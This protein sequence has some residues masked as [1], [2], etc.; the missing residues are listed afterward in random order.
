MKHLIAIALLSVSAVFGQ[1]TSMALKDGSNIDPATWRTKLNVPQTSQL[2]TWDTLT[3]KPSTFTPSTHVHAA[4][5]VT[6]GTFPDARIASAA[7]WNAKQDALVSG[8]NIKTVNGT[9]LLGSGNVSTGG[10]WGS[11][12]GTLSS[13]TD[14]TAALAAKASLDTQSVEDSINSQPWT[15]A[16]IASWTTG[17]GGS[18]PPV[19]V[20]YL[21][22]S[23]SAVGGGLRPGP[24]M[25]SAGIIGLGSYNRTGTVTLHAPPTDGRWDLWINGC[26]QTYAA[27]SSGEYT[28]GGSATGDVR[29]DRASI[30]YIVGSGRG[31][32]DLQYQTNG[33]GAWTTLA[34]IN[35]SAGSTAGA[36]QVYNLP[37]SN[38][39]H[40]RLRVNNVTG[41]NVTIVVAGIY[42]SNGGGA[43]T[44]TGVGQV[45]G[46]DVTTANTT[47]LAIFTPIWT[48]LAPD[49]VLSLWADA[50]TE[51]DAGG[52]WRTFYANAKAAYNPTDYIQIS[53]NISYEDSVVSWASGTNYTSGQ[54]VNVTESGRVA[55][56][57]ATS[58]HTSG[59]STQP[60]VGASWATVWA[61]ENPQ[62]AVE[63]ASL[64]PT[65]A[66]AASQRSWALSAGET[67]ICGHAMFGE[68]WA[69]ANA[70]GLMADVVH[71]STAGAT[72]RNMHVWSKL[73]LG[74]WYLGGGMRLAGNEPEFNGAAL[75]GAVNSQRVEFQRSIAVRNSSGQFAL[76][77]QADINDASRVWNMGFLNRV[78]AIRMGGGT[79]L[80]N[81]SNAIDGTAG[82]YPGS[83]NLPLGSTSVR[84]NTFGS[85]LNMRSRTVT[86]TASVA[87]TDFS[88][89]GDATA[90]AITLNLVQAN[91]T[92][93]AGR[94]HWFVKTDASAN[95]VIIDPSGSETINGASTLSLTSQ[96][97]T[98]CIQSFGASNW[99]RLK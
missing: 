28:N 82:V 53:R 63:A 14:L 99:I 62:P 97:E 75:S 71:P 52:A 3:G 81:L 84:F 50:G 57:R 18:A 65:L 92:G 67:Y 40:Y 35:T 69:D 76:Y 96:W 33:T 43:I 48:G 93:N 38:S 2:P 27:G 95:A 23:L 39:P 74:S 32:F 1:T 42:N 41:G 49:I 16:K 17:G 22:D 94:L 24:L 98:A 73:P 29:G 77:D 19:R 83:D 25:G 21:G 44:I 59:A 31:T 12:T 86:S 20:M 13:Q 7:T 60:G 68:S 70:K 87:A 61:V 11:I 85:G 90:G 26:A 78:A 89:A 4:S 72:L 54:V 15:A 45:S 5:D 8:S 51:W 10:T 91:G 34:T 6:S 55:L 36:Y 47:P 46:L 88:V 79:P 37:T 66:Q 80:L 58:T 9:S 64:A 56:Y 30:G